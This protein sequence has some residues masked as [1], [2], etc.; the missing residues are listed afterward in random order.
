MVITK[1]LGHETKQEGHVNKQKNG[2]LSEWV[3]ETHCT[4]CADTTILLIYHHFEPIPCN[5]HLYIILVC[6]L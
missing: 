3:L 6:L 5:L 2:N 4:S 1:E